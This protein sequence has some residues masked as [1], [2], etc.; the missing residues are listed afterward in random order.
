MLQ[1]YAEEHR[2]PNIQFYVDD[3]FSGADLHRPAFKR[4]MN[5]V[6]FGKIEIVIVKD[7]SSLG[8]DYLQTEMM[9]EITFPQSDIRFIAINDG[10]DS[11]NSISDFSGIKNYFNDFYN[12]GTRRKI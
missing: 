9:M 2:F 3:G 7:Q 12:R 10:V 8:K 4:M 1:K 5:D 11:D 6:K